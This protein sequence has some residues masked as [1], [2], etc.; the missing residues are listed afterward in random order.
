MNE[1]ARAAELAARASRA[2]LVAILAARGTGLDAAE[3]ALAEAF[4]AALATWPERGVPANPEAWLLTV[5]RR[6]IGHARRH[7]GVRAAAAATLATMAEE[8]DDASPQEIPDERLRLL[9]AC[10]HPAVPEAARAPLMLQVVLGLP[11]ER[12][13]SA[14][15]VAPAAMG[16]ALV[17]AKAAIRESG[18]AFAL[19]DRDALPSRLSAVLTAIYAAYGAGWEAFSGADAARPDLAEEVLWLARLTASLAPDQAE[20]L[21]LLSL[22][23]HC[24]ARRPARRD[25]Q[26]RFVPLAEQ[27]CA[28]WDTAMI[29]EAEATLARAARLGAPGR[30]QLEAAI[31]SAH[32]MR[33]FGR[34][35][36]WDAIAS[37]YAGLLRLSPTLGAALGEAAAI[38]ESLGCE[39]AL[40]RL[41][42]LHA[43]LV[44][45]HQPYWAL[46]A[47][48]LA[49]LGQDAADAYAR[50]IGLTQDAAVRAWL[51]RQAA[52]AG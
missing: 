9:L 31:Q 38:A 28:R 43:E 32:A 8:A 19:P 5:A 35:V 33:R 52:K 24:E 47:H 46:R 30:F 14:F 48:L 21:G 11:A 23:L 40:A 1:A 22:I 44:A 20:A 27:A 2:R 6:A 15:L 29:D 50:A 51:V 3:D 4:A 13:A 26:G 41:D 17:R 10:A 16:Q 45:N 18:A 39:P 12:I 42:G 25:E 7:R 36:P 34:A 37:L 49:R